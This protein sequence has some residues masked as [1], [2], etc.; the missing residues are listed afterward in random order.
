MFPKRRLVHLAKVVKAFV[1]HD[2]FDRRQTF[3]VRGSPYRFLKC[4]VSLDGLQRD[5]FFR[6][7]LDTNRLGQMSSLTEFALIM[8]DS[9]RMRAR[10]QQVEKCVLA[11]QRQRN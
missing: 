1:M 8:P 11:F 4:P 7:I 9:P 6:F 10:P 2:G 3:P 5:Q